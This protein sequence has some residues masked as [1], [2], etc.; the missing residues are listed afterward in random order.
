M[1]ASPDLVAI[2]A[3]Q[4]A[5]IRDRRLALGL[6]QASVGAAVG[7][8]KAAVHE[9]E[10]GKSTPRLHLQRGLAKFLRTTPSKLFSLDD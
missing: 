8:T 3:R 4:G 5:A 10:I 7:V 1:N 6:T 9:W 2:R